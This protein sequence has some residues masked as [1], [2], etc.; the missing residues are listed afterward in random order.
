MPEDTR[1]PTPRTLRYLN[2]L[3]EEFGRLNEFWSQDDV[4]IAPV[5]SQLVET[6]LQR[7]PT[8][9]A[10]L[11][12]LI[13]QAR[14]ALGAAFEAL[15]REGRAWSYEQGIREARAWLAGAS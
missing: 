2:D 8:D 3:A 11:V 7:D 9:E 6:G 13:D 1:N 14:A 12:P 4:R 10:F 15:E 5:V